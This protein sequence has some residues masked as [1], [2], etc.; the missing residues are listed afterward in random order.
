MSPPVAMMDGL[1]TQSCAAEFKSVT[2]TDC[3]ENSI[4][5]PSSPES[6]DTDAQQAEATLARTPGCQIAFKG[7]ALELSFRESCGGCVCVSVH[8]R[9]AEN[10]CLM[11][12]VDEGVGV[13]KKARGK[14]C[15]RD[16]G[17]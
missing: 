3:L 16:H 6:A 17:E 2:A 11:C 8:N 14:E 10:R 1:K 9:G 7:Q 15:Y 12:R 4:S 5:S 13:R